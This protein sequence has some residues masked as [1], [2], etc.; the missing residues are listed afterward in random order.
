MYKSIWQNTKVFH[1]KNLWQTGSEGTYLNIIKVLYSNP[2]ANIIL[3]EEKNK[4][5][6]SKIRNKIR[7]PAFTTPIQ[8]SARSSTRTIQ[9]DK[10]K[11]YTLEGKK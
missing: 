10:E 7:M 3:N 11:P 1:D 4:S 6:S 2:A 5:P 9:Q 8:Y